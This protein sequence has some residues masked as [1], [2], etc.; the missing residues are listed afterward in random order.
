MDIV[1]SRLASSLIPVTK[2]MV[3]C[4]VSPLSHTVSSTHWEHQEFIIGSSSTSA[5]SMVSLA[6]SIADSTK[7]G[8]ALKSVIQIGLEVFLGRII[9]ITS[10]Y[11]KSSATCL[12]IIHES[13]RFCKDKTILQKV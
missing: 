3:N 5:S 8:L 11:I 2:C 1:G 10:I 12:I 6:G 9:N 7:P 4:P 13:L